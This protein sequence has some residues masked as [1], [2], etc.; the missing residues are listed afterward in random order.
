LLALKDG[1]CVGWAYDDTALR[2]IVKK[3][4]LKRLQLRLPRLLAHEWAV[5]VR[6]GEGR[7][8]LGRFISAAIIDWHHNGLLLALLRKWNV[9]A[10][11]FLLQRHDFW[12]QGGQRDCLS[13][14]NGLL[15]VHCLDLVRTGRAADSADL[16]SWVM[17][18]KKRTGLDASALFDAYQ[19]AQ[20]LTG[21][22]LTV[23]LSL[24]AIIGSLLFGVAV[25]VIDHLSQSG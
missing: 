20:L 21:L 18:L 11:D 3:H 6:K 13:G 1:R 25:A 9:P 12:R 8:T 16:P 24:V 14:S 7:R 23:A 17:Q 5:A 22:R 10:S 2:Q 19:R 15:P 4:D